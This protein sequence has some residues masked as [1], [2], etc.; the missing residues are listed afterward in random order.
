MCGIAGVIRIPGGISPEDCEAVGRMTLAQAHRGPDASGFWHDTCSALGHRRLSII[1]LSP[2]GNQPLAS[3]DGTIRVICNGEI[4]NYRELGSELRTLGHQF[5]S[6]SDSEVLVHGYEEWGL[7]GLLT[8]LRGMFAFALYDQRRSVCYAARDR[9]GIKPLYYAVD[10]SGRVAFASEVRALVR[11]GFVTR[12]ADPEA[13]TGFL[14]L[15]SVPHPGTIYK[16]AK[17]V[18]PAH[19]LAISRAGTVEKRYWDWASPHRSG[20]AADIPGTLSEA[21]R[22]HLISD[23]KLGIFLSAGVDSTALTA[24]ASRAG[25]EINTLTVAFDHAGY[26]EATRDS[27]EWHGGTHTEAV[28][29]QADFEADLPRML[30]A[31]DQPGNDGLN[32]WFVSKAAHEAGLRAVLSGAGADEIFWGYRHQHL[33]SKAE[34]SLRVWGLLP[35]AV[36]RAMAPLLSLPSRMTRNESWG[37]LS[38]LASATPAAT[39]FTGRGFFPGEVTARLLGLDPREVE[40]L[41]ENLLPPGDFA[42]PA[43]FQRNEISRYLHDQLLR[44]ADVYGMAWSLEIRVPFLDHKLVELVTSVPQSRELRAG[45]NKP[46]LVDAANHNRVDAAGRR[47]KTGFCLPLRE[48]MLKDSGAFR[49]RALHADFL[50]KREVMRLWQAFE[51]GH[52]NANRAWSLV[53]LGA[54]RDAC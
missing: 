30:A 38:Q 26:N 8:R 54:M 7:E 4:Y 44:D 51:A 2:D 1:D 21:I 3:E 31:I 22:L 24:L 29:T 43:T 20:R 28:V 35:Q 39:Y 13:L 12:S 18:E 50:D 17:C 11:G 14:L 25:Q 10:A 47:P 32:T 27:A 53:V 33:L 48:W 5:R 46:L 23:A 37:R 16:G 42:D 45:V 36:R 9:F 49:E 19:Y 15:G 41:G 6:A 52:L 34:G 40:A